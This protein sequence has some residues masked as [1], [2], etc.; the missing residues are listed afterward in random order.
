MFPPVICNGDFHLSQTPTIC[1]YL[2]KKFGL[3]PDNEV[4]EWHADQ[5]NTTIHDY[6]AEGRLCFHGINP[7]MTYYNQ[8]EETKPYIERFVAERIPKWLQHFED[9][10]LANSG[11]KGFIFGNNL[12]YVDLGLMHALRATESQFPDAWN[13]ADYIPTLKS[14]KDRMCSRPRLAAYFKSDKCRAF[15]GNSMM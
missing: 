6:I 11:G 15:E 10:L 14:F 9:V 12:T 7:T 4:D 1:K 13:N 2:G 8:K 5:I 3:Y